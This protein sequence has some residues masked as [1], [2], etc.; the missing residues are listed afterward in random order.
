MDFFGREIVENSD[1]GN[2]NVRIVK[3]DEWS[4]EIVTLNADG[5]SMIENY[6]YHDETWYDFDYEVRE[7]NAD[8]IE[9][10]YSYTD[11]NGNTNS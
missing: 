11:A 1:D 8:G 3:V 9:T 2:G 10:H 7:Y 6:W 5:S 4:E